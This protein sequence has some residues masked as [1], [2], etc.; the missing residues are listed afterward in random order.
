M[1]GALILLPQFLSESRIGLASVIAIFSI[2][3]LSLVVLTGWAGQVS[4]GQV[5][6]MGIGAAVGGAL[7]ANEGFDILLAMLIAG[8]VG[9]VIAVVIG[10]PAIRRRGLTL[11]VI[12]L[13]FALVTQTYLLNTEF[14]GDWLPPSRIERPDLFG[15]ISLQSEVSFFYFSL[16]VLLLMMLGARGIRN[17][18]TG[19][20]LVA[21]REN[22]NAARSYGINAVRDDRDC[23]CDLRVHGCSGRRV[24]RP[25]T[26]RSRHGALSHRTRA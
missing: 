12:T 7:T 20:S 24:V 2:V 14:F 23:L 17:S 5:A 4:L 19:R 3:A 21:V 26:E 16:V 8:L 10:Y 22:E 18:R 15:V 6:F 11:A 1:L 9:A 13:A 25:P